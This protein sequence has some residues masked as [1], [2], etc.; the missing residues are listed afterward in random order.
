ME[1]MIPKELG[2]PDNRRNMQ[3]SCK[4]CNNRKGTSTDIEFRQLNAD[5][6][7]TE[8]RTPPRK[9]IDPKA[10]KAGAQGTRYREQPSRRD[11]THS[12]RP[13]RPRTQERRRG[14]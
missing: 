7:P 4:T 9:P 1:H 8:E 11:M 3:L 10:L 12:N 14:R 2:G 5:L 13:Q 6:I